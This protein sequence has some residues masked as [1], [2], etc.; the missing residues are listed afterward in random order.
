MPALIAMGV[1]VGLQATDALIRR[2]KAKK[3]LREMEGKMPQYRTPEDIQTQAETAIK[4][5]YTPE[6]RA[7]FMQSA[8]RQN[9]AGYRRATQTNPN[10]A[11][12]VQAGINYGGSAV[13]AD[14]AAREAQM[15]RQRIREFAGALTQADVR[16]TGEE[17]GMFR[18]AAQGY[19][20][21][22]QQAS[23]DIMNAL[24]QGVYMAGTTLQK[25]TTTQTTIPGVTT[26]PSQAPWMSAMNPAATP[27]TSVGQTYGNLDITRTGVT[28][29][30]DVQAPANP[31]EYPIGSLYGN[32]GIIRR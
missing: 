6:E 24:Q 13:L 3:A 23:A 4:T 2:S 31:Y 26:S 15:R 17:R 11:G 8:A 20:L 28:Q 29:P 27:I 12:A 9:L 10:L 14:F 21:A 22:Q 1:G 5:G 16:K 7:S 25:P 32:L 18:E 19:G 30:Y